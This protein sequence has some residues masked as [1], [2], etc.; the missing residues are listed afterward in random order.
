[1]G[2]V[3]WV[4]TCEGGA[5]EQ[6]GNDCLESGNCDGTCVQFTSEKCMSSRVNSREYELFF[7]AGYYTRRSSVGWLALLMVPL[8]YLLC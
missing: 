3:I 5:T 4:Q 7:N 1:M 8:V 6:F 2:I